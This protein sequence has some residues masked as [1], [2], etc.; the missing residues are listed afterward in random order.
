MRAA[1]IAVRTISERTEEAI[2]SLEAKGLIEDPTFKKIGSAL[3][4]ILLLLPLNFSAVTTEGGNLKVRID[5]P[6]YTA[7]MDRNP[8]QNEIRFKLNLYKI[9][10]VFKNRVPQE[11]DS[12]LRQPANPQP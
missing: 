8:Q 10:E 6:A 1:G 11:V 7:E 3:C 2:R 9:L 12:I 5:A 4:G